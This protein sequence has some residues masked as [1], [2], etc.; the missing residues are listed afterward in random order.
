MNNTGFIEAGEI[1]RSRGIQGDLIIELN[2]EIDTNIQ[3]MYLDLTDGNLNNEDSKIAY[4]VKN[5][6]NLGNN[7]ALVR[8]NEVSER[9]QT[10]FLEGKKV[11]I[12]NE[13]FSFNTYNSDITPSK[14]EGYK[15]FDYEEKKHL[16]K[17]IG[18][19]KVRV[20]Y[21][22]KTLM[23]VEYGNQPLPVPYEEDIIR[24]IDHDQ[25]AVYINLPD[26]FL[27]VLLTKQ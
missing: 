15:I 4:N 18:L 7:L 8:F 14:L 11:F 24:F 3:L 22:E 5:F 9:S 17:I 27:E 12:K 23:F 13:N 6:E 26:E 25:K 21:L 19:K 20:K 1:V 16:G 2:L 10:N